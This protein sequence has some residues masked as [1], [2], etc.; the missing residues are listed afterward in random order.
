MGESSGN[1]QT[2]QLL[3]SHM[4]SATYNHLL[5]R[6]KNVLH[7]SRKYDILPR[8]F[9]KHRYFFSPLTINDYVKMPADSASLV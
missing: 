4:Q 7:Q 5:G 2:T 3:Q 9:A 6:D 8:Y 1:S